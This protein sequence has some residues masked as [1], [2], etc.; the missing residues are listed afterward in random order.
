MVFIIRLHAGSKC[1]MIYL[2]EGLSEAI[3]KRDSGHGIAAINRK[4]DAP[5]FYIEAIVC[6]VIRF[7]TYLLFSI[8]F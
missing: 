5:T 8:K 1:Y 4:R 2:R 3:I 7:C 6:Y